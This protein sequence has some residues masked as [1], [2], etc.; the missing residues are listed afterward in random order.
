MNVQVES[1]VFTLYTFKDDW[2]AVEQ[3]VVPRRYCKEIL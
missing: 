3:I 2:S 1:T